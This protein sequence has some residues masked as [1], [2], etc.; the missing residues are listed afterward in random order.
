LSLFENLMLDL[1]V[2]LQLCAGRKAGTRARQGLDCARG[3]PKKRAADHESR[4]HSP[5]GEH[6]DVWKGLCHHG[7]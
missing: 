5:E 2:Q 7:P 4:R 6:Y 3:A 1:T